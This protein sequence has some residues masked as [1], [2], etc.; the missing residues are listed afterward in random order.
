MTVSSNSPIQTY[1]MSPTSNTL[2]DYWFDSYGWIAGYFAQL[3]GISYAIIQMLSPETDRAQFYELRFVARTKKAKRILLNYLDMSG[4]HTL[5]PDW[6]AFFDEVAAAG[7]MRND[8]LHNPLSVALHKGH[9]CIDE[10]SG[11]LLVK[12]DGE[13][14]IT[15]GEVQNYSQHL[16]SLNVRMAQLLNTTTIESL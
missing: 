2:V 11:V 14:K 16:R 6:A 4:Q 8:I 10:N 15:L 13:P 7:K 1:W 3:E 5:I 9:L 12:K